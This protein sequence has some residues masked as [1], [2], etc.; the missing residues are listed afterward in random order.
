[1]PDLADRISRGAVAALDLAPFDD[2]FSRLSRQVLAG[3]ASRFARVIVDDRPVQY[4]VPV[5]LAGEHIDYGALVLQDGHAGVLWRDASGVDRHANVTLGAGP[6]S[7]VTPVNLGGEQWLRFDVAGDGEPLAF[8]VPPVSTPRLRNTLIAFFDARPGQR[9]SERPL[10]EPE[11]VAAPAVVFPDPEPTEP[12]PVQD[13]DEPVGATAPVAAGRGDEWAPDA[14]EQSDRVTAPDAAAAGA[15]RTE[16][17]HDPA[18]P[19]PEHAAPFDLYRD[20]QRQPGPRAQQSTAW[21]PG[22]PPSAERRTVEAAP[23]YAEPGGTSATL[24]GFLIG[25][26]P[27]LV[28]GGIALA[29]RYLG[30]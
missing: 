10:P 16:V 3:G 23:V 11:P 29:I 13:A 17:L 19:A 2:R 12:I 4:V 5:G 30:S 20:D 24:R 18:P 22:P 14:D 25:L 8:L 1:M 26:F 28:I 21:A 6:H 9:R 7:T 27:T 15:E